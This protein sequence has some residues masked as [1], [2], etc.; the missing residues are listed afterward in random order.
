M[1]YVRK[2]VARPACGSCGFTLKARHQPERVIILTGGDR[3]PKGVI[4]LWHRTSFTKSRN[5]RWAIPPL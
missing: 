2:T 3:P 5:R 1:A 4:A